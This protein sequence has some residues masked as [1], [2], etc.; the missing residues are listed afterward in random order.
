ML[1]LRASYERLD[2]TASAHSKFWFIRQKTARGVILGFGGPQSTS[3]LDSE[4]EL[5][6]QTFR[7]LAIEI[8]VGTGSL[9]EKSSITTFVSKQDLIHDLKLMEASGNPFLL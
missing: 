6:N 5:A 8:S 7:N 3:Y 4:N 2:P 9:S 1:T